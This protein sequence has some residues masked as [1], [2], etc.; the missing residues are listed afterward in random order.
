MSDRLSKIFKH[1]DREKLRG[2]D[3]IDQ[4]EPDQIYPSLPEPPEAKDSSQKIMKKIQ[5]DAGKT[6]L[7][8]NSLI[9]EVDNRS[10]RFQVQ[11]N[12]KKG[13]KLFQA[14]VRVFNEKTT[15]VTYDHYKR[16]LE[17]R[18]QLAKEDADL[19]RKK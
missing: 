5:E 9:A 13:S 18:D 14:M 3:S 11:T 8:I 6:V 1:S 7:K 19:L 10:S 16:A 17:K 15:T 12:A 4:P 2:F